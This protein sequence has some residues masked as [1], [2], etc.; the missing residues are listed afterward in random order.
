MTPYEVST[1][2]CEDGNTVLLSKV[3]D[4]NDDCPDGTDEHP[5]GT[6]EWLH[7]DFVCQDD[8]DGTILVPLIMVNDGKEDCPNGFDEPAYDA[9]GTETS[10]FECAVFQNPDEEELMDIPLSSVNDGVI[11]CDLR[12]DEAALTGN[13]TDRWFGYGYDDEDEIH[14]ESY[15]GGYCE[16]EGTD[17]DDDRWWCKID[18]TDEQWEEWWY[19]CE[20][21]GADWHC[22]DDFGQSESHENSA[23]GQYWSGNDDHPEVCLYYGDE[24]HIPWSWVNDGIDDC[25]DGTDEPSYDA[26]GQENSTVLCRD[27][28][29]ILLSKANDGPVSYTHL[30]AHETDS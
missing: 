15:H 21:H 20:N 22:T 26:N 28:T 2:A 1:Y 18:E 8:H 24:F 19:Y 5:S 3:N 16:W 27:G 10:Q 23:D 6:P 13:D 7:E 12:Q 25:D 30:R 29:E 4:G 17:Q 14:W 11:D 9:S